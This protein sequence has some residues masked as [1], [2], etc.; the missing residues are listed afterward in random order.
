[1]CA[2]P[3]HMIYQYIIL[4]NCLIINHHVNYHWF[5]GLSDKTLARSKRI[6]LKGISVTSIL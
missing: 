2:D 1:M 5:A 6:V 4:I 3:P